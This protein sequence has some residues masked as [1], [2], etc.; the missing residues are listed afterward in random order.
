LRALINLG[1]LLQTQGKIDEAELIHLDALSKARR[2]LG[3]DHPDTI[4]VL[5]SLGDALQESGRLNE[6]EP[7][8]REALQKNRRK[9]GEEH[10][11]TLVLLSNLGSLLLAQ[12]QHGDVIELL[13]SRE[14]AMRRA[15]TKGNAARLGKY[16]TIVGKARTGLGQYPIAEGVLI[17]AYS[18]LASSP[19]PNP[20]NLRYCLQAH[21]ELYRA[22]HEVEP[23]GGYDSK[24]AEWQRRLSE[25]V[26]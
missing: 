9:L 8:Y 5:F 4:V 16:L 22:W 12:G 6:A 18:V 23:A 3:E 11:L 7:Y 24:A 17:E 14:G 25:L 10:P 19:G 26:E 2:V 21:V 20:K 15:F 1:V 13:L